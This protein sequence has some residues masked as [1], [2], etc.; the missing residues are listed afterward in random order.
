MSGA[1][2]IIFKRSS[3]LGKRPTGANLEAGEIGLNTNS[4][5]PGLFFEVNDGSVVKAGPTAYLPGPPTETPARGELWVDADTKALSI[6][7]DT[8]S[9]Q[10]VAAPYLG[11]TNGLTV[12]VAPEYPNATDD[13]AN[14]GQTVPFVTINR[15]IIEVTKY[16]IQ[17]TLTGIAF[18]NNRYLIVL[19]PGQHCVINGPGTT[20][21]DF[22]TDYSNPYTAVTQSSLQQ[23][24]TETVGGLILPRGV[25]IIGLDLKKCEIHPTYVPK[26]THPAFPINYQ[27][28]TNG[29]VYQ[30]EPLSSIFRWS[31]NTYLSNFCALDK[32]EDNLVVQ[33]FAQDATG[34]A[35]FKTERPHGLNFN[36]FVQIDYSFPADQLGASFL[37]GA[38]YVSPINSYEFL[39]SPTQWASETITAQ[40]VPASA[41]PASYS[42]TSIGPTP[43][44]TVSGIYPYYIPSAGETY[45]LH[46]YSHH[47]L[48]VLK[49]AS[50]QQ[51]NDFY[52]KVQ[53]A[54]SA[55]FAGQVN[56]N[57]AS[58][59]AP[60]YEIVATTV[61]EYPNNLPTN[62]TRNS[63]P[64]Q[65]T[66]NH[67]SDYGMSNGDYDGEIVSGF[68]S[69]IVNAATAVVLQKDP[70]AYELYSTS[71]QD[72][73]QLTAF[74]QQTLGGTLPI[75]SIPVQEQLKNLNEAAIP[76]IRYYYTTLKVTDPDSGNLKS[77]GIPDPNNDFRH[78]GFRISGPNS[79][80]QAQSTYTIGAAIACWAK[81]G[82]IF[83]LTNATS[84]FGS[85]AFQAE[86]FAGMGTLGG[87]NQ[88]NKGFLLSGIIRPLAL[89]EESVVSSQQKR[90]LG[91]GS[92]VV[93]VGLDS[94]NP[95]V[96]L[97][98][99][100]RPFDPATILPYSL[101]PD[102]AVYISDNGCAYRA[103]FVT[104]G[105]P[106]CILSGD[107]VQN[108]YSPGGAV[109]RVRL[110][111]STIPS[112]PSVGL[113]V[114]YIRRFIDPRTPTEQSYGFY[115]QSTNPTS[116]AP[117]TGSVLRLNQTGQSLG[118]SLKRNYQ[119]DPGQYGGI[120]QIFT[121]DAVETE[122]YSLSANF[123]Y[124]IAD[125]SQASNYSV[126]AT[127]SD[128]STPWVQSVL[129]NGAY[130]P[131]Y[132]PQGAYVVYN[133]KN[134]YAAENNSWTALYYD[135]TFNA[136]NGPTKVTPDKSDS[137]FVITSV[138]QK[139][140]LVAE[141]W[142]GYV[143]D[144]YYS[145]Y[146][147]D[148]PAP[149]AAN[150]SYMRGAVIPYQQ[151]G[152]QYQ[153]DFDDGT[154][155]LGIIYKR[156]PDPGFGSVLVAPT[157]VVQTAEA[158]T[159]PFVANP[160][161]GRPAVIQ[162]ELLSVSQV[163]LP[164]ETL[165]ILELTN[166]ALNAREYVRVIS[167]NS[168]IVQAI[169][170]YYPQ[171]AQGTLPAA[172]PAGTTVRVCVSSGYP[173]PA[174]YDPDWASTKTAMFRFFQLMGYAPSLV[175]QYLTPQYSGERILLNASIPLSPINGYANTTTAWPIEFNN[176]SSI[177]ANTHTWQYVGY[178]DYSRGLPKYQVNE[179][180]NKLT[181][182]F[183]CTTAWG[184]R[185]TVM[186]AN[187][188]G[189]L[190]FLGPI[191]EAL[192]AKFFETTTPLAY[193]T[194]RQVY[195]APEPVTLPNP[196]L[197][198]SADDISGSFDGATTTFDLT[199]G[200]YPIPSSQLS[201]NGL[202][203]F[204]GG[205]VQKPGSA[206]S[207]FQSTGG[208]AVPQIVFTEAPL[209]GT[210]C[211]IRVVTSDDGSDSLEVVPFTLS[212]AFDD[213][214]TS[215]TVSPSEASLT[216]LNSFVFLGGVEQNPSGLAQT[217]AAYSIASSLGTTTLSFIGGAPQVGTVLDMRGILSG[218]RYRNSGVSAVFVSSVDDI[219]PLFDNLQTTFPLEIDG[220]P[221][222]PT[223][224]NAQNMFVSLGGVMQIPVAQDG[225][226]LAGLAYTVA[227]N[228]VSKVL[229]ITFAAP[230]IA[231]TTCNIRVITSD[232]LLT[233]PL[234]PELL[235]DNLEIGPGITVNR[236]N[237]IIG[238]DPGLINP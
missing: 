94:A 90:V 134:Y 172:W 24:N 77:T 217:S 104:D 237:Q 61:G 149:Y 97:I 187:E 144:P 226:P 13:L 166:P 52:T 65:N 76:N 43:K 209:K 201:T 19:A 191:K 165:S 107:V 180:P 171:Y 142:Q 194:D 164:K 155:D 230:P 72:W 150:L 11:G 57:L 153:V 143:P 16:I 184:G 66:V 83:S 206:Y 174:M 133:N 128:A 45:E 93:Y 85:V 82:A 182:D 114:P 219:A 221:L 48:S 220:V 205:V 20:V 227:V 108:P 17:D 170:N 18:G 63:S 29:P 67:R 231:L 216:N 193:S 115:I 95:G 188:D 88:V 119:F 34:F 117:Q 202:F 32:I 148:V 39:A 192:T 124:K 203:V 6:G 1:V 122:Q 33:T 228:P 154:E 238:I 50:V 102:T 199:R 126:Y 195:T 151:F 158:V 196:V 211:D 132:N 100:Q 3:I 91:L 139:S 101:K 236:D 68:K 235:N 223:K 113:E 15:A 51:L 120:A 161:F 229:E 130:T 62:S 59:N 30:N 178:L 204:L 55:F 215:F 75:T 159:S 224:V 121:V 210:S 157:S 118:N 183:L 26:Y 2:K 138:I 27:Q 234:P 58:A 123:N 78:F 37:N 31:G 71:S 99:L 14:D 222:D 173:E 109:L 44:F 92:K 169:R 64:Y 175:S 163:T 141:S 129:Q 38:Y 87:A 136:L 135:T 137:P 5:D 112:G 23:F 96:Q 190:I 213:S 28:Q 181:Y 147:N 74:T 186:G 177:I 185:L 131:F 4:T 208:P 116:Q 9:W 146:T 60:E 49:N 10:T 197:V 145:Y 207:V 54:F 12:F 167:V 168:N 81:N 214:Q 36:D 127:L 176:P 111:D 198:Y 125:A 105:S 56:T 8:Q 233:C 106:T 189:Q 25:S 110:S 69:V 160:T 218:Q 84:N 140:E 156:L 70:V 46:P 73:V 40:P 41:L 212:P 89:L 200:G 47:R 225:N 103:Y 179:I 42:T 53:K 79:Y 22:T 35:V 86:G 80:I 152:I 162:L 7:T 21:T 232:E 98:Y